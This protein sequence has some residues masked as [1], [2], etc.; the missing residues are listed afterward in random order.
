LLAATQTLTNK[1]LSAPV[2]S[3]P[4]ATFGASSHDYSAGTDDWTLSAG[5]LKS[6]I[7]SVSNAGGAVNI[8]AT[9]TANRFYVV[10]NGSGATVTIK[11]SGETGVAIANT[12]TA[13]V[14]ANGTDF[15][16]VTADA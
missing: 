3:S 7:L 4:D 10:Y 12:K 5:E 15:V 11:A 6:Q 8:L 16:R 2:I 1:T 9:P 14:R 13:I